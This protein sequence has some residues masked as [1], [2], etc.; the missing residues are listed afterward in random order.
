MKGNTMETKETLNGVVYVEAREWFDKSGGN[1]YF[2]ARVFVN[3]EAVEYLPF[4]YGYGNH[5]E[6]EAEKA[7]RAGGF[8]PDGFKDGAPL[9]QL[10]YFG[11]VVHTVKYSAT[12]A[13]VK[14]WG[15]VA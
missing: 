5:F 13:D 7:L 15:S 1:S 8:L 11:F 12:K 2:S 4:Q 6:Y 14:R 3:G 10:R 9:W